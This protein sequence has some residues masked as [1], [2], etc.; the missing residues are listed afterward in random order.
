M[1]KW[2][3]CFESPTDHQDICQTMIPPELLNNL[4][5]LMLQ[6]SR[7]E[8][9]LK[10]FEEGLSNCDKLLELGN[11][12]DKRLL[13]LRLTVK[14]NLACCHNKASR[15]GEASEMYKAI[16]QEEPSYTEA[17]MKLAYLAQRR[18]DLKRAIDY[19]E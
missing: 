8:D 5:V 9:A 10:N 15:I 13:A 4:G 3:S 12:E 17:Y 18:G 1:A 14:F 7:D 16:I 2:P 19:I 6:E 11:S